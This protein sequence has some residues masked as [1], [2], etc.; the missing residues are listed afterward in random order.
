[1]GIP[2]PGNHISFKIRGKIRQLVLLIPGFS[3][4]I[5]FSRPH[6]PPGD[7]DLRGAESFIVSF[8]QIEFSLGEFDW[9]N[10]VRRYLNSF[11]F[12]QLILSN[13]S[14][15]ITEMEFKIS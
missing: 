2:F 5:I 6:L 15:G 7:T 4:K 13:Y 1:M 12:G 14:V 8:N 9:L 11:S 3:I 10:V